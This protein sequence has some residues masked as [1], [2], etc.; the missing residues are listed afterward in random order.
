MPE[1]PR[2]NGSQL[3]AY[4][5]AG[6]IGLV[7]GSGGALTLGQT[8]A[9]RPDPF[10]GTQARNLRLELENKIDRERRERRALEERVRELEKWI[11]HQKKTTIRH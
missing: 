5:L 10:T 9:L 8:G 6:V 3:R 4:I 7:T 11:S 1:T 2:M